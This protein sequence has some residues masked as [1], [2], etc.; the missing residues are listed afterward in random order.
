MSPELRAM[1]DNILFL[2]A[3]GHKT[4]FESKRTRPAFRAAFAEYSLTTAKERVDDFYSS[5][6]DYRRRHPVE[7]NVANGAGGTDE[8]VDLDAM[9][10]GDP[11]DDEP[12]IPDPPAAAAAGPAPAPAPEAAA[13]ENGSD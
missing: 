6:T 3:Y 5:W 4:M 9:L 13:S 11:D 2:S 10:G 8:V 1:V 7:R 12:V